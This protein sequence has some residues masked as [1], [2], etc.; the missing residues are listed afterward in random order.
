MKMDKAEFEKEWRENRIE[1]VLNQRI[2]YVDHE[3]SILA[4]DFIYGESD[5]IVKFMFEGYFIATV[6]FSEIKKVGLM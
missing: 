5:S 6:P 1:G 3:I 2:V 4:N